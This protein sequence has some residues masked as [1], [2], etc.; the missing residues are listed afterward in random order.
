MKFVLVLNITEYLQ[1][2]KFFG[3]Y[4][5]YIYYIYI[6]NRVHTINGAV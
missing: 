3:V 2:S 6:Y 4:Y 5:T 1:L